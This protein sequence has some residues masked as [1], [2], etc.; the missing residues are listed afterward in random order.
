MPQTLKK[1]MGIALNIKPYAVEALKD[2]SYLPGRDAK[3]P[4][5]TNLDHK[6]VTLKL[7]ERE[8]FQAMNMWQQEAYIY[9][10]AK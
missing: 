3:H 7:V 1:W 10:L 4:D 2:V 9:K 5:H 6:C 8:K